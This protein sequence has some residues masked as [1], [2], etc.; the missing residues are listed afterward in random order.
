MARRFSYSQGLD[1]AE[2]NMSPLIDM[3]F[4]LLIFFIVTTA[5]VEEVGIEI[6]KPKA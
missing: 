3:M 4:L 5:F 6:Q 2:I 1:S